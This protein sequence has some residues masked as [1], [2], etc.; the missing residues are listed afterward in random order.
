MNGNTNSGT[1]QSKICYFCELRKDVCCMRD[2]LPTEQIEE[3]DRQKP[4]LLQTRLTPA[5]DSSGG[6][7]LSFIL[8][9]ILDNE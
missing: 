2:W 1:A 4:S 5:Q 8:E 9:M 7:T 6:R 3:S